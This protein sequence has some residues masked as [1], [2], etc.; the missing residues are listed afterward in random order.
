MIGG[1]G[2]FMNPVLIEFLVGLY[3]VA[4][5]IAPMVVAPRTRHTQVT[6]LVGLILCVLAAL[7]FSLIG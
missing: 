4:T 1:G 6:I 2:D 5:N 7:R 3:M